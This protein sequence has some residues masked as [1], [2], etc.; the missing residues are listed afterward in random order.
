L[1]ASTGLDIRIIALQYRTVPAYVLATAPG[2]KIAQLG[3]L[4]GKRIGFSAGQEQG[5]FVLQ[6]LAK[7]GLKRE[8]VTLVRLTSTEFQNALSARQVDV[9]PISEPQLTTYL[10]LFGRDGAIALTPDIQATPVTLTASVEV[11]EDPAKAAAITAYVRAWYAAQVWEYE[12]PDP[13]IAAYYVRSQH[14]TADDGKRII[15]SLGRPA[16]PKNWDRARRIETDADTF[17]A[18][19]KVVDKVD[20]DKLFDTRFEPIG[21]SIVP[22]S[23]LAT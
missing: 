6:S 10:N 13:W 8:Q 20:I 14:V 19:E 21:A 12:N 15:A 17:L 7:A 1:A 22:P 11:L 9:A 18:A 16:F 2:T 3:D 4:A 5:L 23:Y